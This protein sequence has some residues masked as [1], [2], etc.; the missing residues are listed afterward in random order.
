MLHLLEDGHSA[1]WVDEFLA[2]HASQALLDCIFL[3]ELVE[4]D[5]T[6]FP[7]CI[8]VFEFLLITL[9][10]GVVECVI[11]LVLFP[12]PLLILL[13]VVH[14]QLID[15]VLKQECDRYQVLS[16]L[17][18]ETSRPFLLELL[19]LV[20]VLPQL[21]RVVVPCIPVGAHFVPDGIDV[22]DL[23]VQQVLVSQASHDLLDLYV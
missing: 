7:D 20:K 21:G 12:V 15:L 19:Q 11:L 9:D 22:G 13:L 2:V 16:Q 18:Q 14:Q 1:R 23:V 8:V 4:S 17:A 3:F 5:H 6:L 10:H